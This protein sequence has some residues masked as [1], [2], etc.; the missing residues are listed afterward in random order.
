MSPTNMKLWK[1]LQIGVNNYYIEKNSTNTDK[2]CFIVHPSNNSLKIFFYAD[3]PHLLKLARN[4][5]LDS[6]FNI[7]GVCVNKTCLE[8]L[9]TLNERDLKISHK[10]NR[11]H[12]DVKGTQRQNV[13]LAAQIFSN[14]NALAIRWCGEKGFMSCIHWKYT[15]NVLKLFNDWFDIFNSNLKYGKCNESHA[16]GINVEIQNKIICNMDEFIKEIRVGQRTSLMQFQKGILVCNKSLQEMFLYIQ[17]KYSSETFDIKYILTRRLNQDILE[18][19]FS[20]IRSMGGAYDHPTPLEIKNRLKWYILGKH[21][22][23]VVSQQRNT[24]GDTTS[25]MIITI[26]D[27]HGSDPEPDDSINEEEE[28]IMSTSQLKNITNIRSEDEHNVQEDSEGIFSY[29]NKIKKIN[30][31]K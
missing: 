26:A 9:L 22:E 25:K 30:K 18:N 17:Q 16:Y 4:N 27:V 23:H 15:S 7:K 28:L 11:M 12:I 5:F 8:E 19:F 3:V 24:E 20:Y 1:E 2:N 6:G 14:Q 10:L 13:K 29:I 21:S 31:I